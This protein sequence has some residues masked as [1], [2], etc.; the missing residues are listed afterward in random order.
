MIGLASADQE[1]LTLFNEVA[2][3]GS[4]KSSGPSIG[5]IADVANVRD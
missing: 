1:C 5:D 2:P 4:H 3:S